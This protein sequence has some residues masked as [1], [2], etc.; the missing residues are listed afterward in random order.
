MCC[1]GFFLSQEIL[2]VH[3]FNKCVFPTQ[4]VKFACWKINFIWCF[5][6]TKNCR[7]YYL[8]SMKISLNNVANK[9]FRSTSKGCKSNSRCNKHMR[10]NK[11][12]EF[13]SHWKSSLDI[14][15]MLSLSHVPQNLPWPQDYDAS[16]GF[17]VKR[18]YLL[19]WDKN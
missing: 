13:A 18:H 17:K 9:T 5:S 14:S 2:P 6:C 1:V 15:H 11:W 10:S 12:L 4:V 3:W 8:A 16:L 19:L 7:L